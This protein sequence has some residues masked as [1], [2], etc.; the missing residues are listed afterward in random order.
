MK[1]NITAST[2]E[3]REITKME[4][5]GAWSQTRLEEVLENSLMLQALTP[6]SVGSVSMIVSSHAP[7]L[8]G[9]LVRQKLARRQA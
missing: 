5:I 4:R 1:A 7:T 6:T 3:L 2:S 8:R 9:W